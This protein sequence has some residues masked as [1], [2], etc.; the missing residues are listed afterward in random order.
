MGK[1]RQK[2]TGKKTG[3]MNYEN[4]ENHERG[5]GGGERRVTTDEHR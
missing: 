2:E 5:V 1:M 3:S 4:H